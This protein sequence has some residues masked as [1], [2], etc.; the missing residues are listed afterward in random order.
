MNL[1]PWLLVGGETSSSIPLPSGF[2]DPPE[3][4]LCWLSKKWE[5]P[6][7]FV[8]FKLNGWV[9]AVDHP[10]KSILSISQQLRVVI[11]PGP[12]FPSSFLTER[13]RQHDVPA[14]A[15]HGVSGAQSRQSLTPGT[16][17]I[18]TA[19]F[20]L[21]PP[22]LQA[23]SPIRSKAAKWQL[24]Q[25]SLEVWDRVSAAGTGGG[26]SELSIRP[27]TQA[28]VLFSALLQ[29]CWKLKWVTHCSASM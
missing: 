10:V 26:G 27:R 2:F 3:S 18:L 12:F 16:R 14:Y 22:L 11:A 1:S 8:S 23:K 6:S 29:L 5:C 28:L 20:S 25:K 17:S 7:S 19:I 24:L 9:L 21:M 4:N 15:L 13:G